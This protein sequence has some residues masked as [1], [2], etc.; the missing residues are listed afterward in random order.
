MAVETLP[1]VFLVDLYFVEEVLSDPVDKDEATEDV[2]DR[3]EG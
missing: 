2:G 1:R 3:G